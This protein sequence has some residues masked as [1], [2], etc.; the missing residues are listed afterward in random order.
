MANRPLLLHAFLFFTTFA[1]LHLNNLFSPCYNSFGV[2][3]FSLSNNALGQLVKV[4]NAVHRFFLFRLLDRIPSTIINFISL[5]SGLLA[6]VGYIVSC[7]RFFYPE[8]ISTLLRD[9]LE[10]KFVS[11]AFSI[12]QLSALIL[13]SYKCVTYFR[14][15]DERLHSFPEEYHQLTH[16]YRNLEKEIRAGLSNK[17][18]DAKELSFKIQGF[19]NSALDSLCKLLGI[20]T[21]EEVHGCIKLVDVDNFD[22]TTP[23]AIT[24][25]TVSDFARSG[26]TPT[27]RRS[28]L[29]VA[30]YK[31][32]ENTDFSE[33]MDYN[34]IRNQFYQPDL[35]K[36]Q[37]KLKEDDHEYKNSSL[38]WQ[39]KYL[40]TVVV[41]IQIEN[42]L[43]LNPE[44]EAY[45]VL[46]FLCLDAA[47]PN[48]FSI[49]RK[50]PVV[51]LVKAYADILYTVFSL[52]QDSL[53]EVCSPEY[54]EVHIQ[55]VY[56]TARTAQPPS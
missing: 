4:V 31:I 54:T 20:I 41:P 36:Y 45:H 13:L 1:N 49:K 52:F 21:K 11:M 3:C 8:F 14:E 16:N 22:N 33:L 46:G 2:K 10:Y 27:N 17:T 23:R 26:N 56:P 53:C 38:N 7:I 44:V 43:L 12:I 55:K 37:Q 32:K 30:H 19:C 25:Q 34:N 28:K 5:L 48:T 18:M 51:Q 6:L 50:E 15:A 42:I 35:L 40:S 39:D 29:P 47:K 24:T 9:I